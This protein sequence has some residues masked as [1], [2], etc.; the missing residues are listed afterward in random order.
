MFKN[1]VIVMMVLGTLAV[2]SCSGGAG[3]P[4]NEMDTDNV[5]AIQT[6]APVADTQDDDQLSSIE[7][8]G[9]SDSPLLPRDASFWG[10]WFDWNPD[11]PDWGDIFDAM[12]NEVAHGENII[13][14]NGYMGTGGG[15]AYELGVVDY[16]FNGFILE[17]VMGYSL[18]LDSTPEQP[19]FATFGLK[20]FPAGERI[21]GVEVEGSGNDLW[22]GV[23][24]Y[25]NKDAYRWFGPYNL[26]EGKGTLEM[27]FLDS[28]NDNNYGYITLLSAG[29]DSISIEKLT[30]MV[31]EQTLVPDIDWDFD[32][33]PIIPD[34]D[35]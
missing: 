25:G 10:E 32:I 34:W 13:A 1:A 6:P 18:N 24:G 7:W 15:A 9:V 27:P 33:D 5:S 4:L 16:V 28:T 21:T 2:A 22:I 3:A 12:H 8:Q 14:T 30:V 11:L 26:D 20:G 31:G 19:A 23:A 35:L 17:P 29:G